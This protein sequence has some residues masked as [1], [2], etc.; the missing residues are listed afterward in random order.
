MSSITIDCRE[1][2]LIYLFKKTGKPITTASLELGDIHIIEK[3]N[4]N[5][6]NIANTSRIKYIIE[7]KTIDDLIASLKD[8]RYREQK[9][10]VLSSLKTNPELAHTEFLYLIEG[11]IVDYK[12]DLKKSYYGTYISLLLR[13]NIK[14]VKTDNLEET[15]RFLNRLIDRL[16]SKNDLKPTTGKEPN[17]NISSNTYMEAIKSKKKDNVTPANCQSLFLNV[18]PGI[19]ISIATKIMDKYVTIGDLYCE[20]KKID[21]GEDIEDIEDTNKNTI[22][23]QQQKNN[24]KP[25]E[26]DREI[27]RRINRKTNKKTNRKNKKTKEELKEELLK[28]IQVGT[29]RKLGKVLSKRIYF[30]LFNIESVN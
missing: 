11:I 18:I 17:T 30:Y 1:S 15:A 13:D 29:N 25:Q 12:D 10:R 19:S 7:R 9:L 22:E 28:D 14:I 5:I 21:S 6:E 4:S 26:I 24:K 16:N 3:E 27:D 23:S 2:K 20:Y 8:G